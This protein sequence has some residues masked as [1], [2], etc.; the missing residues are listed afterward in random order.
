MK[1]DIN[2]GWTKTI[3]HDA[4]AAK[5]RA[6]VRQ[7]GKQIVLFHTPDGVYACNNRCPHEGYPLREGTLGD[8][9]TL[10]C[11]WH[12]WKF[13]LTTGA[14]YFGGDALRVY[15]VEVR[16][17]DIWLDL[18]DPPREIL[19]AAIMTNL[20]DAFDDH[21]YDRIA[22]EIARLRLAG[23]D[24]TDAVIAAIEWTFDRFEFGW[25][26]AYAGTADWLALHDEH[27]GD[28]ETQLIC[29]LECVGHMADDS[30]REGHHPF[31]EDS[32]PYDEDGFVAA[33]EN[34]D[35][36]LAVAHVRGA[37]DGGLGF[38]GVERGLMRAALAHYAD[39]GHSLIYVVKAGRL[40]ERLGER[41]AGPLLM[42]LTRSLIYSS[43]EDRIPEFRHYAQALAAWGRGKENGAALVPGDFAGLNAK[44][45]M[46]LT[47]R[48]GAAPSLELY[49]TLL[50]A[51]AGNML[52]Y[53]MTYQ[54]YTEKPI[55]DN[56]GWLDF[57]H[58]I[59]FAN[60][61]RQA[62]AKHPELWPQG[63]LQ[64]ACFSGR[65]AAYTD[66]GLDDDQW[67]VEDPERFFESAIESLFDHGRDEY[68][69]SVHFLKTL[70]AARE[71]ARTDPAS[72]AT[73][74]LVASLN[75]LVN[76]TLKRK[77]TRR[78]AHQAM[79][80]VALDG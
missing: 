23:D 50:A 17:G 64:M 19:R 56:V 67:R 5:G 20:R 73:G 54:T 11:D 62:C 78:V 40:I 21:E 34:E 42:S 66:P 51:N 43:R 28:P 57:T 15:P 68:I 36:D 61:L 33:L 72:E 1:P 38:A 59:T 6:V 70:L 39:F 74:P 46:K 2:A 32:R 12:N 37:L 44:N 10:T 26:H 65:N 24:A 77:H 30:L 58:A 25:T 45:A 53:D 29:L 48:H 7:D 22:R 52:R 69:V 55:R 4:L 75:R 35:E 13:D 18:S 71:E 63:L 79:E 9:C 27:D 8:G 3:R 41:V 47:A 14:N 80:F 31:T 60:A 16:D 49:E 76:S